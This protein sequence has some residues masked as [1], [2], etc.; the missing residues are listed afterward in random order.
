MSS[1]DNGC[2]GSQPFRG[3][4]EV[5]A[6]VKAVVRVTAAWRLTDAQSAALLDVGPDIWSRMKGGSF[7]E[8][9]DPEKLTR[10]GLL[11][12]IQQRLRL[13]FHGPLVTEWPILPNKGALYEG[14][15]PI[16]LMTDQGISGMVSVTRH[17]D[18]MRLGL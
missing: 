1:K 12:G 17:L 13:L 16:D 9:I 15:R 5:A 18:A 11:I 8:A 7:D 10:A 14:R 6:V 3:A 2:G 4:G